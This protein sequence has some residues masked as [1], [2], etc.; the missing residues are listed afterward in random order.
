LLEPTSN[1]DR[2]HL[3]TQHF[4]LKELSMRR[5]LEVTLLLVCGVFLV[6]ND[7]HVV[8]ADEGIVGKFASVFKRR[9]RRRRCCKETQP[10]APAI[11]VRD[12]GTFHWHDAPK[13]WNIQLPENV[14]K[15]EVA[16]YLKGDDFVTLNATFA[17][18][19][20][21]NEQHVVGFRRKTRSG[22][23]IHNYLEKNDYLV[24]RSKKPTKGK[25]LDVTSLIKPGTNEFQFSHYTATP[26]GLKVR[27]HTN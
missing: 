26:A 13:R 3:I 25:F 8:R 16:F 18:V 20:Q 14:S 6:V 15:V 1:H 19:L 10:A 17:G 9:A 11:E 5:K 4:Q 7:I 21:V 2:Q 23:I 27:I 12:L 24:N 22:Y